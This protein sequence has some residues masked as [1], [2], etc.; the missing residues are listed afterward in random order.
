MT[1]RLIAGLVENHVMPNDN[2]N[3]ITNDKNDSNDSSGENKVLAANRS[4]IISLA[5]ALKN[6]VDVERS[7]KQELIELGILDKS[8]FPKVNI[9]NSFEMF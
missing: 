4:S 7:V 6:G 3:N 8:D 1:Q 5:S 9:M 2:K